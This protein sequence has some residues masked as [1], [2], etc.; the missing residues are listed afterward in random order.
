MCGDRWVFPQLARLQAA[1][2]GAEPGRSQ[3]A[4]M[5]SGDPG[6]IG[7]RPPRGTTPDRADRTP[8]QARDQSV[9]QRNRTQ[10]AEFL[11]THN[12]A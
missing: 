11:A 4:G 2:L 7:L 1:L 10:F 9:G 8:L 3:S 12:L 5:P 6:N